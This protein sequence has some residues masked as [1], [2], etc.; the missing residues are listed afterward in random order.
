MSDAGLAQ[1]AVEQDERISGVVTREQSR[2]RDFIRRRVPDSRDAEDVL[3]DVFYKLV[4]A[5]RLLMPIDH[6][7]GWL[8][9]VAR[10]RITDL[11]RKKQ[12][13]SL[14]EVADDELQLDDLLPSA[15]AGP[16]ALYARGVLALCR[17]LFGRLGG[18]G[19]A[20]SGNRRRFEARWKTMTPDERDRFRKGILGRYAP[21][22]PE[23]KAG[24]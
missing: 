18:R 10:N 23:P 17:I 3:Q 20:W 15:D 8:F 14:P 4:E 12:P 22:D 11:F 1:M 19:L 2:L 5:N 16:E 24:C 13:E 6:V 7:T 9:R 21:S